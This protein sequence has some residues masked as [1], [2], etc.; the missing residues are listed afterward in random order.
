M[1][2][3]QPFHVSIHKHGHFDLTDTTIIC[4]LFSMYFRCIIHSVFHIYAIF[5][6]A[7]LQESVASTFLFLPANFSVTKTIINKFCVA[8]SLW[9]PLPGCGNMLQYN[10]QFYLVLASQSISCLLVRNLYNTHLER[11]SYPNNVFVVPGRRSN[12]S[13]TACFRKN[14]KL[15]F[16]LLFH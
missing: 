1:H 7:C 8:E 4:L 5:I 9:Q 16:G 10:V 2:F 14:S 11:S 6:L 3:S 12:Q 13:K 15:K